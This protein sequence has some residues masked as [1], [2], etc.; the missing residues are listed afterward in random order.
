MLCSRMFSRGPMLL[1]LSHTVVQTAVHQRYIRSVAS[2]H[3]SNL[4][5]LLAGDLHLTV[6]CTDS[7]VLYC[8][9]EHRELIL[10]RGSQPAGDRSRKPGGWL[11]SFSAMP[12]VTFQA[13][14]HHFPL[15]SIKLCCLVTAACRELFIQRRPDR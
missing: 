3:E 15:A 5:R 14:E 7:L 10:V 11:L 6:S 2:D 8:P 1:S 12:T 13:A 9:H 4:H